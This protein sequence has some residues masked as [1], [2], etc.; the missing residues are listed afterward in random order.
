MAAYPP[1]HHHRQLHQSA[2]GL[3][4]A[5]LCT[6]NWTQG[7]SGQAYNPV[8]KAEPPYPQK[9]GPGGWC[10]SR[11]GG[12]G[13]GS[14]FRA[15]DVLCQQ[16]RPH[17]VAPP[18][19]SSQGQCRGTAAERHATEVRKSRRRLRDTGQGHPTLLNDPFFH[20]ENTKDWIPGPKLLLAQILRAWTSQPPSQMRLSEAVL[21]WTQTHTS[22]LILNMKCSKH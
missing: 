7:T 4:R 20:Q 18:R 13:A 3:S 10:Q 1:H 8:T 2:R 12:R 15:S 21:A 6:Q 5:E 14:N 9:K 19:G 11:N 16:P 22:P 17:P